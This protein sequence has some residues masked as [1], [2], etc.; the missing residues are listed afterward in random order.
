MSQTVTGDMP[1]KRKRAPRGK[2]M[3]VER[4]VGELRGDVSGLLSRQ[5]GTDASI[6]ELFNQNRQMLQSFHDGQIA[7]QKDRENLGKHIG[8]MIADSAR[9]QEERHDQMAQ[10]LAA[11]K[12]SFGT[13]RWIF[14]SLV[15][16]C[17]GVLAGL[18]TYFFR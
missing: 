7:A 16:L 8:A 15:L 3:G 2:E 1:E 12:G 9:R 11:Q 4:D 13:L 5:Q 18:V 14:D 6:V 17:G 10:Q